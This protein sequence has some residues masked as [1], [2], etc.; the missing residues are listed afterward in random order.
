LPGRFETG[1]YIDNSSPVGAGLKPARAPGLD[2]AGNKKP[3]PR[4]PGTGMRSTVVPPLFAAPSQTPPHEV[5]PLRLP[6]C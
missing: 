2:G 6:A 4:Q 3:A 5:S 1:S